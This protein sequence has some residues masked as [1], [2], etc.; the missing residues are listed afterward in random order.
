MEVA[1]GCCE[2]IIRGYAAVSGYQRTAGTP[3]VIPAVG[4]ITR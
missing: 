3:T 2:V 4:N 1:V